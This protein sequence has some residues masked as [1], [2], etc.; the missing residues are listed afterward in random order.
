MLPGAP[1]GKTQ[2]LPSWGLDAGHGHPPPPPGPLAPAS[3]ATRS[4]EHCLPPKT[5]LQLAPWLCH[6]S[7]RVA[8]VCSVHRAPQ[9]PPGPLE[10]EL[11]G[12]VGEVQP[13]SLVQLPV[14]F[15]KEKKII[16]IS[17]CFLFQ[18]KSILGQKYALPFTTLA[19]PSIWTWP[20][21][22]VAAAV[23]GAVPPARSELGR[24][25]TLGAPPALASP[26]KPHK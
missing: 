5:P 14:L 16:S 22:W 25:Q 10:S 23:A 3:M 26:R 24:G 9:C 18:I 2:G 1:D 6:L 7:G 13:F 20:P 21:P 12:E 4:P 15:M 11:A 19:S 17:I 8:Q